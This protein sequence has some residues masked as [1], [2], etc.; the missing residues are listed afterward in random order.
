[1]VAT[2]EAAFD[3]AGWVVRPVLDGA[4][5]R[6]LRAAVA[7]HIDRVV[8]G[9]LVPG[10]ETHPDAGLDDRLERIA[11]GDDPSLAALLAT[12]VG[13]DAHRD[14][15]IASLI[16][17]PAVVAAVRDL[18]GREADGGTVR[19]RCNVP[20]LPNRREPWHTDVVVDDGLPCSRVRTTCWIPLADVGSGTGGLEVVSGRR[21]TAPAHEPTG[22]GL[23]IPETDLGAGERASVD[24]PAGSAVFLD[25]FTPHRTLAADHGRVRWSAVLWLRHAV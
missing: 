15:A 17:H 4:E 12:A 11:R 25:R 8:D 16:D 2:D 20:S 24:C 10:H 22:A 6:A 9:L 3:G 18:T 23:S 19:V 1:M 14:P 21:D 13:T 7:A 5:V